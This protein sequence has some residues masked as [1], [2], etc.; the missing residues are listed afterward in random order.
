MQHPSDFPGEYLELLIRKRYSTSTIKA[1]T[2]YFRDFICY[3][4]Q[5]DL[6]SITPQQINR[7]ILELI[8]NK[9]ISSSQQNQRINAIKF[10]YEKI[11]GRKREYYQIQRPRGKF[12][13]HHPHPGGGGK[14]VE[15]D[16]QPETQMHTDDHLFSGTQEE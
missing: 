8:Q 13:A 4:N 3:F 9:G 2:S 15:T 11:L 6:N 16:R 10:Y 5:Y 14:N 1:Y 12:P 7:Y